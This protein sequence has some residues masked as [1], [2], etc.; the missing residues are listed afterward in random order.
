[1]LELTK[2]KI[3]SPTE[4]KHMRNKWTLMPSSPQAEELLIPKMLARSSDS[5]NGT[6]LSALQAHTRQA[7]RHLRHLTKLCDLAGHER[8]FTITFTTPLEK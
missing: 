6:S 7:T 3:T 4:S 2:C 5:D 8:S 1:M